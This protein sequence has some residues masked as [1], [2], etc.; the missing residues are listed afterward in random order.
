MNSLLATT[1][2]MEVAEFVSLL[3]E[4]ADPALV[5]AIRDWSVENKLYMYLHNKQL[6]MMEEFK[7][8]LERH[9]A[10]VG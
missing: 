7:R 3:E 1:V 2:K 8:L 6:T 9:E 5:D 10:K 4:S